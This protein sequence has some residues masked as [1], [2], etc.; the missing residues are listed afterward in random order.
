MLM[1]IYDCRLSGTCR[2]TVWFESSF[3]MLPHK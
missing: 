1:C 2:E 3:A